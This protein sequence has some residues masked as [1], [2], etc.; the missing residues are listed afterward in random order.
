MNYI[1]VFL[2]VKRIMRRKVSNVLCEESVKRV[3]RRKV[4]N[5]LCESLCI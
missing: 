2:S 3:M 4:L 1:K 5:V